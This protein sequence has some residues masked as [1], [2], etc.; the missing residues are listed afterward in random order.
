[1]TL[2]SEQSFPSIL[3]LNQ[4]LGLLQKPALAKEINNRA[5]E[6]T[7]KRAAKLRLPSRD[8]PRA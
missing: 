4:I 5:P 8:L 1:M 7:A 3:T 2:P 6:V